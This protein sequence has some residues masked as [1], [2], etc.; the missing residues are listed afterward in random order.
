MIKTE[1][2]RDAMTG[3]LIEINPWESYITLP[4]VSSPL[5]ITADVRLAVHIYYKNIYICKFSFHYKLN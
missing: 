3:Q 1:I 5:S 2:V 4:G